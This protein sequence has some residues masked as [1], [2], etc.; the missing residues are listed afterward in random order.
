MWSFIWRTRFATGLFC[1]FL[2]LHA[3][4][5]MWK[6]ESLHAFI[7]LLMANLVTTVVR[8]AKE[9]VISREKEQ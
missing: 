4:Y 7:D 9:D 3:P 2:M 5:K 6:G 8:I 1:V